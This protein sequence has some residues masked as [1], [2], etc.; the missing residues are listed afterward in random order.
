MLAVFTS[1][2]IATAAD[3]AN[4]CYDEAGAVI[5][6]PSDEAADDSASA[7]TADADTAAEDSP[8]D[9]FWI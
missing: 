1:S 8:S 4:T 2:A 7:E 5:D 3:R 6:C 9:Q